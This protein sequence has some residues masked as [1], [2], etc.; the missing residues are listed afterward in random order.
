[1]IINLKLCN[2]KKKKNKSEVKKIESTANSFPSTL[3]PHLPANLM[4]CFTIIYVTITN[5]DNDLD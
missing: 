2:L 4:H 5:Y 3:G 1:M